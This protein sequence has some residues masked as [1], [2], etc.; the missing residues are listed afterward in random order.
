MRLSAPELVPTADV[1]PTEDILSDG[2]SA[3]PLD[4]GPPPVDHAFAAR[5]A[6]PAG[7][8]D[9]LALP[10]Q[11]GVVYL[12][13][14]FAALVT[15]INVSPQPVSL[16]G[17][18]V[19]MATERA[20][21][22]LFDNIAAPLPR[23]GPGQRQELVIR[24]DVKELATHTLTT[25]SSYQGPDGERHLLPQARRGRARVFRFTTA[26]PLIV[27]TRHR[28]VGG[29]V[30]LEATLE[31]ATKSPMLLEG[32]QLQAA[33][34]FAAAPLAPAA[35][36]A[37]GPL[38]DYLSHAAVVPPEGGALNFLFRLR[39]PDGRLPAAGG[40]VGAGAVPLGRIHIQWRGPMGRPALLQTQQISLTPAAAAGGGG[41]AGGG[42]EGQPS[43]ELAVGPLPPR[44]ALLRPF[45]VE[46]RVRNRGER[47][48]PGPLKLSWLGSGSAGAGGEPALPGLPG[49]QVALAG[50]QTLELPG[51]GPAQEACARLEL[52]P[53]GGGAQHVAGL[54]LSDAA[55]ARVYASLAP[56]ELVV[57]MG[58]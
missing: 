31:N 6:G 58:P 55:G 21:A 33:A 18:R 32:V 52:L 23:L 14:Q 1:Y 16:V 45:W 39:T 20:S 34:P 36:P 41:G 35:P 12:G 47:P 27:R 50:P 5:L 53:L 57:E 28:L 19:E 15:I 8:S 7:P 10:Q 30:L 29:S 56:V 44:V 48:V 40:G 37:P 24:H 13:T 9:L 49:F 17:V 43:L 4:P 25:T 11:F 54:V 22:L 38:G 3:G 26:N 42:Q 46:A 2:I 51:L